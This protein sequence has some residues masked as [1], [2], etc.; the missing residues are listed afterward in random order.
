MREVQPVGPY[1][2]LGYSFGG[3]LAVEVARQLIAND[4]TVELVTILDAYAPGS[5]RSRSG[6]RKLATHLRI[7]ARQNTPRNLHVYLFSHSP[8]TVPAIQNSLGTDPAP[9]LPEI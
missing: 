3:N 4:Q 6:L 9:P 7:I 5:L 1:A 2:I 8:E